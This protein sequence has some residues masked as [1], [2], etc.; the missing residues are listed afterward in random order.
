LFKIDSNKKIKT[1]EKQIA[2]LKKERNIEQHR[3]IIKTLARNNNPKN[4]W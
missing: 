4:I 2:Q 3:A 1:L